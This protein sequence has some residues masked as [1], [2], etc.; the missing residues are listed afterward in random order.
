MAAAG[1]AA[2]GADVLARWDLSQ[3][4]GGVSV[5]DAGPH[6]C[7]GRTHN[8]PTRG[9]T[10]PHWTS[11]SPGF[12]DAA[13]EYDA[14]HFHDDDVADAGWRESL[15]LTVPDDLPSGVYAMRLRCD[16]G[17][18]HLPFVV[19]PAAG[20]PTARIAFLMPTLTYLAYSNE[21]LDT[22]GSLAIAPLQDMGLQPE[23][24][25][26]MTANALKSTY[27]SHGDGSGVCMANLRRPILDFRP[28][29]RTRTF[30]APHGFPADLCLVDWLEAKGFSFDVITD[31]DL[32]ADGIDLLRP[33]RAVLTG[34]HPEYWTGA[35]LDSLDGYLNGGGR[36]M[37]LGGNGFYWVT[38]VDPDDPGQA[39]IRR[40]AGTRTWQAEPGEFQISLT[41]E[42][43][44]LW[45]DRGRAPQKTVGVG[46]SGQ[47]FD[48][49]VPYVRRPDSRDPRA[50]FV[51]EGIE[52]DVFGAG[53]SLVLNH[54]A[55]GFEVDRANRLLGTPAHALL[56]ASTQRLSDAY[57]VC[58]E[59]QLASLPDTGGSVNGYIGSDIVLL[60]YPNGGAV[61]SVGSISW[62]YT[63]SANGYGGDTSRI[64][65]NVLRRFASDAAPL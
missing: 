30:D 17:E 16:G 1:G 6:G 46:F 5:V 51:F 13:R 49:G 26:Y 52:G 41:G 38:A 48:R 36:L 60:G 14:I 40:F 28:K 44:G 45:R 63:L 33:Y 19:R 25:A 3:D 61:F 35:M 4:I 9:V 47:G 2:D 18:D 12:A 29:A 58:I 65:E 59:E 27:D 24:Y 56:L 34:A 53:P 54:G 42:M 50:A 55:G 8:R 64:T 22:T 62:L 20:R 39:E 31:H 23:R 21:S 57:Q 11:G 7:H 32:H 10:G 15:A 37:Y 43:G